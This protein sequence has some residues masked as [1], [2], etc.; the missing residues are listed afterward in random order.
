MKYTGWNSFMEDL[1]NGESYVLS[2]IMP[3]PFIDNAASDLNTVYTVLLEANSRCTKSKQHHIFLTF[4]QTLYTK[5]KE[6]KARHSGFENVIIHL[7]GFL[8]LLS[9]LAALE[10][11]CK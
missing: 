11:L 6:V 9:F 1:F 5:A 7:G 3:L 8:I 4:D 2:R 10:K